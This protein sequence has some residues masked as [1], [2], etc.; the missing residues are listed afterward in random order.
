VARALIADLIGSGLGLTKDEISQTTFPLPGLRARLLQTAQ[1][2]HQGRGF[3]VLRGLD[4]SKYSLADN[5]I[6]YAGIASYIG[7]K[8]G[9]QDRSG[10]VLG[11]K[12]LLGKTRK[13]SSIADILIQFTSRTWEQPWPPTTSA[14]LLTPTM[15]R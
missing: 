6:L 9:L 2:V 5:V 3:A 7:N 14:S 13:L 12:S 10:N 15:H 1:E 8:R 4:P 11:I